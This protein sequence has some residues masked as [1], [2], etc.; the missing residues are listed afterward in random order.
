M[1]KQ[2]Q[3]FRIFLQSRG[4]RFTPERR[5]ILQ[6]ILSIGGHFDVEVL[7][8]WMQKKG[9]KLSLATI[10]RAM[11]LFIESNIITS[12]L[13]QEGR[14]SYESTY[15]SE[16]HDHLICLKCGKIIEFKEDEIE[17]LQEKVCKSYEFEAI[18]HSLGIKGY[19]KDCWQE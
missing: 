2:E 1:K 18:E 8:S 16:H 19:C 9:Y 4:L 17:V 15:G 11:P 7:H 10:Y 14:T 5:D 12:S 13:R 6:S 3:L